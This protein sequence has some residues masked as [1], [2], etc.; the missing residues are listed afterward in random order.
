MYARRPLPSVDAAV[1]RKQNGCHVCNTFLSRGLR[2]TAFSKAPRVGGFL[3]RRRTLRR[4]THTGD[5]PTP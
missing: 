4:A 5:R 1:I 3:Q 2:M